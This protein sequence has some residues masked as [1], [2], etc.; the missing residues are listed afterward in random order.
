MA[1]FVIK[2]QGLGYFCKE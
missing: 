2:G 1:I